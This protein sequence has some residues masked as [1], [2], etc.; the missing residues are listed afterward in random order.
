[1]IR[2]PFLRP[3]AALLG[4]LCLVSGCHSWKQ[5]PV[6]AVALNERQLPS[7]RVRLVGGRELM[8]IEPR[9]VGDSLTGHFD[10]IGPGPASQPRTLTSVPVSVAVAQVISLETRHLNGWKTA[11]LVGALNVVSL[12]LYAATCSP[13]WYC[14][15]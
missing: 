10:S 8:I 9:V 11:G 2:H 1:M 7:A 15:R 4:A 5:E 6:S 12:G 14:G 13:G 3:V